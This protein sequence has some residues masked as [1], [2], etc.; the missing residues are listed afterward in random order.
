MSTS[1]AEARETLASTAARSARRAA[2]HL[3]ALQ[4]GGGYWC[5][6]LTADTTLESDYILLQLWL[7]P[8]DGTNWN[9]PTRPLVDKAV[10]SIL[11]RQLPDGGFNIYVKG[12]SEISATVKAYFALKVAGLAIDDPRLVRARDRILALGGIQAANSYVKINLSLFDM[13]PRQYCPSIPPEVMLLPGNFLYQMSAW[14]R[15]IVVSLAIVHSSNPRR[16]VPAGFNLDEL[17]KPGVTLA[18]KRSDALFS[19]RNFFLGVDAFLK[20]WEKHGSR[21]LRKKA[22][23]VAE[24]WMLARC[25]HSDGLGAIYP[26]M[27]YAIMALDAL[28]Y[29][30]DHPASEEARYQFDRLM[31]DDGERFLF[32]PC[33]S[34]IWDTGIAGFAL[35]EAQ[36]LNGDA[37]AAPAL[38]QAADWILSK[39]VRLKGDWSVKRPKTEPSGWGF[40]FR[41]DHYPDIDDTAMILLALSRSRATD[42]AAQKACQRAGA[43]V[44]SGHAG[45][46]TAAGRPSMWTTIGS[47]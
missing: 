2:D 46:R 40:F 35:G 41:N 9:P 1:I 25:E 10:R 19:W 45:Q 31:I 43:A 47:F 21:A 14:T 39:E 8:P 5:A 24:K 34:P 12:P 28:G 11:E 17:Y 42:A 7:H 33:F 27:M 26:P 38:R 23:R 37:F 13:Y 22:M 30:A 16:P 20:V 3:L 6:D 4:D 18:F 44:D 32:Q 15:A 36:A 29:P